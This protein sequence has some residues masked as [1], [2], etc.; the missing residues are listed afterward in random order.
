MKQ[1][2]LLTVLSFFTAAAAFSQQGDQILGQWLSE[3]KDGKIE[4]YKQGSKFFGKLVWADKMYEADG[5]TSRK[6]VKNTDESQRSRP[7]K[8]LILLTNF[9]YDDGTYVDGKIYDPKSGKTYSCKM[10]LN[11]NMLNIRGYVGL[12]MFGR[13]SVWTR[14]TK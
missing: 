13:T 8:D 14:A 10:T 9:V 12:P 3:E 11:G 4:V 7:L 2:L 1:F 5:K 6:D